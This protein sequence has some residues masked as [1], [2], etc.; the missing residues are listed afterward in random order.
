LGQYSALGQYLCL[1]AWLQVPGAG[2]GFA[3]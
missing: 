1:V 2:V 3:S